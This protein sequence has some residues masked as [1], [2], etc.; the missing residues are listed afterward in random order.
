MKEAHFSQ[1]RTITDVL[2]RDQN[3]KL[4]LWEENVFGEVRNNTVGYFQFEK[5]LYL[6]CVKMDVD[7]REYV[8]GK[9]DLY[10]YP[11]QAKRPVI[12]VFDK[13][14]VET[15][16]KIE[17][18]DET[19]PIECLCI[20]YGRFYFYPF[21]KPMYNTNQSR[22][23]YGSQRLIRGINVFAIAKEVNGNKVVFYDGWN[24][25]IRGEL[26]SKFFFTEKM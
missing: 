3:F 26:I 10:E 7:Q 13:E 4:S 18:G 12:K 20:E 6:P 23:L 1:I 21:Q 25:Y 2:T 8:V 14:F 17:A 22:S 9:V 16:K 15:V 24:P 19:I 5:W 11:S